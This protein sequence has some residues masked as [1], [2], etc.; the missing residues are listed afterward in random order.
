MLRRSILA[1]SLAPSALLAE[2]PNVV[3]DI[4]PIHGLVS[5]IM[6]DLGAPTILIPAGSS[7]HSYALRPSQARA[8]SDADLV[9]WVGPELSPG[10]ENKLETLAGDARHIELLHQPEMHTHEFRDEAVFRGGHDDHADHDDHKGEEHH[11]DDDHHDVHD[12][13]HDEHHDEHSEAGHDDHTAHDDHGE[14][15]DEHAGHDD[16]DEHAEDAH[17][18]EHGHHH[19]GG[20]DP[21][22]WLSPENAEVILK[23]TAQALAE[24]DAD[25]KATY[26]ANLAAALA[27]LDASIADVNALLAPVKSQPLA[28]YHDAFQYFEEAFDLTVVGAISDSDELAPGPRRLAELKERFAENTPVCILAEPAADSRLVDVVAEAASDGLR[29]VE[30]D[31]LGAHLEAGAQFYPAL[32]R[33]MA[34]RIAACVNG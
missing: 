21:H 3:T 11:E 34:T 33:D 27:E 18:D 31:Q 19:A 25:N 12:A 4:A 22:I 24:L 9:V 29:E 20:V 8:L 15:K 7:P 17:A 5:Q 16:H 13:H 32:L 6:G 2:V 28:V 26:E 10:I 30:V 23:L 1:L 14:D